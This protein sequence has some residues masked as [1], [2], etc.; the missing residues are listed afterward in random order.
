MLAGMRMITLATL[1]SAGCDND[2]PGYVHKDTDTGTPDDTGSHDSTPVDTTDTD[3]DLDDD[4]FTPEEG[5]CNDDDIHVSPA[6]DEETDDGIDNDCDGRV[7]EEWSGVTVAR[8]WGSGGTTIMQIDTIGRVEDEVETDASVGS[9][10]VLPDQQ[11]WLV[12]N[13]YTDVGVVDATGAYTLLGDFSDAETYEFGVYAVAVGLDG[14]YYASTVGS[15]VTVGTDGT[16]TEVGTWGCDLEDVSKHELAV[17]G[18]SVDPLTGVIGLYDYFGGF[19]TFD[20]ASGE[21]TVEKIGNWETTELFTFTGAHGAT[22]GWYTVG[23]SATGYGIYSWDGSDW[24]LT[25]AWTDPDWSPTQLAPGDDGD[26]YIA[27]NGG[28]YPTVWRLL[29]G[30]GYADDFYLPEDP[31]EISYFQSILSRW[32]PTPE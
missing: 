19:G 20:P 30:S 31:P 21:V 22:S 13:S 7:D 32:W 9:F 23:T 16:I 8:A 3:G 29:E 2:L 27:A 4:G 5:D 14:T 17:T 10:D 15:L 12:M 26:F 24:A 25:D 28:W 11:S 18:L 1:L 6:R